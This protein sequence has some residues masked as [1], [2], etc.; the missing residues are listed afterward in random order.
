MEGARLEC[1]GVLEVVDGHRCQQ[2]A[3]TLTVTMVAGL[4]ALV[5][6]AIMPTQLFPQ[7]KAQA[8]TEP[9]DPGMS[10]GSTT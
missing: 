7:A 10:A 5:T 3:V 2:T 1:L 8:L 4:L 6:R 9:W